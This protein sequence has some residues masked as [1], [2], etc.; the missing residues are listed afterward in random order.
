MLVHL[1]WS[2]LPNYSSPHHVND[3]L[4]AQKRLLHGLIGDGLP[5]LVVAGTCLEYG[6]R[7]G[8]LDERRPPAPC[9][10]Y[11]VAKDLLRRDLDELRARTPFGLTWARLFFMFG[12]GQAPTSLYA[13]LEAA[14][15]RADTRFDMSGGEQIRDYLPVGDVA[16]ALVD[17][18]LLGGDVGVVNVCSGRPASVRQHVERWI[19]QSGWTI[20]PRLGVYP[21]PEHEP[22]SF[23]GDPS[24]LRSLLERS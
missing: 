15:A 21:Y 4:P 18:A 2:G 22:M 7:T 6:P 24:K 14:V 19:V 11:A 5:N 16:A 12:A 10:P 17:L 13:Q 8:E 3:E 1:A 20:E 23:W 9:V